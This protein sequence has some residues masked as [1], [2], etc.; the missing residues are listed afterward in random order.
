MIK[1]LDL[2]FGKRIYILFSFVI[3]NY[4]QI[5]GIK[6]GKKFYIEGFPKLKLKGRKNSVE[7]GNNIQILG[8]IDIRTRENGT[9]FF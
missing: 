3:K 4:L 7:F 8:N 6:V 2:I 5:K 9:I 1:L